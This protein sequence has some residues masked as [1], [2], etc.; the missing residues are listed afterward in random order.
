MKLLPTA[1][2]IAALF[3]ASSVMAATVKI[4]FENVTSFASIG[5]LYGGIG[6]SF[7]DDALGLQNAPGGVPDPFGP[8]YSNAPSALGVM[9][10]VGPSATMNVAGG[11]GQFFGFWYS[12]DSVI[13]NGVQ[14]WSGLNGAGSLLASFNL[15]ANATSGGCSS[16]AYCNFTQASTSLNS[17]AR[18]VTFANAASVALFDNLIIPEPSTTMLVGLALAGLMLARRGT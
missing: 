10:V 5:S 13:A 7:G 6:V 14:V 11:F 16:S 12:S 8:Y 3:A 9:G 4:D 2:A 1:A 15:M 17:I 18:S